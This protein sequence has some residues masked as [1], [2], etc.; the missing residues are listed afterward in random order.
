VTS[1]VIFGLVGIAL[2]MVGLLLGPDWRGRIHDGMGAC[3]ASC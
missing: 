3:A 1:L 2:L